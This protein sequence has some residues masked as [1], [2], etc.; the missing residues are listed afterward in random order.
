MGRSVNEQRATMPPRQVVPKSDPYRPNNARQQRHAKSQPFDAEDL[1]RRLYIVIAEREAQKKKQ[2]RRT[3]EIYQDEEK[4]RSMSWSEPKPTEAS[5]P[6]ASERSF[7]ARMAKSK[8]TAT[9]SNPK[10]S[11]APPAKTKTGRSMSKSI[12]DRLRRKPS[13]VDPATT[14]SA[15]KT[16]TY[17]HHVPQEAAAHIERSTTANSMREQNLAHS[18]SQSTLKHH[19]AE[20]QPPHHNDLDSGVSPTEPTHTLERV[21]SKRDLF[22][23]YN[24]FETPQWHPADADDSPDQPQPQPPHQLRRHSVPL[25]MPSR[26]APAKPSWRK[27]S[28]GTVLEDK[29]MDEISSEETLVPHHLHS[30]AHHPRLHHPVDW[31]QSDEKPTG[32]ARAATPAKPTSG[33]IPLLRKADSLWTLKKFGGFKT[34]AGHSASAGN[35]AAREKQILPPEESSPATGSGLKFPRLGFLMKLRR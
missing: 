21:Q 33:K 31:S 15:V 9:D 28:I 16:T 22:H 6:K 11:G 7:A 13:E 10:E 1:R 3:D 34:G 30:Q 14:E 25:V 32:P 4:S 29:A 27:N 2:K 24:P 12:Q 17:H 23:A 18:L 35:G 5:K 26:A 19:R 8:G 20:R